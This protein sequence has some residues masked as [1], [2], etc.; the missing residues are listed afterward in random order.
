MSGGDGCLGVGFVDGEDAEGVGEEEGF[1][2]G[3]LEVF[4]V[5]DWSERDGRGLVFVVERG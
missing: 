3:E 5:G 4:A 1:D 2:G